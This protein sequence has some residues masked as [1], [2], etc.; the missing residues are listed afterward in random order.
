M[1][2]VYE[3]RDFFDSI[4]PF[5]TKLDFDNVGLLVGREQTEVHQVLVALD[6]TDQVVEEAVELGAQ[7]V[8]SHH[9]LFF[10]LKTIVDSDRTGRK[11]IRLLENGISAICLHT[12]MDAAAGGVNDALMQ[13][14]GA[15]AWD[16]LQAE[17][18]LPDGRPYGI[19]RKGE[20]PAPLTMA[21]FL[22]R[23]KEA[24]RVNGLRYHD[25]GRPV[26]RVACCGGSGGSEVGLA[27]R[28]GCDTYVTAD[29]K[30]DQFLEAKELGLNLIDADHFCTENLVVP[31]MARRLRERFPVT[32][33]AVSALHRQTAQFY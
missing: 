7:L 28:A 18:T 11:I 20:L 16:L 24:L 10:Q 15:R 27:F 23:T 9:P 21:E 30:Y 8:V 12:N 33:V 2:R 25:A 14:L 1:A 29:I 17:G 13:A 6:I 31:A 32:E 3:I 26:Q 19:S 22:K 5:S 4:A